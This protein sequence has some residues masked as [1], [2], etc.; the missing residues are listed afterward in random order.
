MKSETT[1]V[2][3]LL[4]VLLVTVIAEGRIEILSWP[5][6]QVVRDCETDSDSKIKLKN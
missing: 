1:S 5:I 2:S 6:K 3:F 4:C